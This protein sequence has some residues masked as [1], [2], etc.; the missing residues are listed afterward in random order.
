MPA[1]ATENSLPGKITFDQK[2]H[3]FISAVSLICGKTGNVEGLTL[4]IKTAMENNHGVVHLRCT[5]LKEILTRIH[6]C[7]GEGLYHYSPAV[8]LVVRLCTVREQLYIVMLCVFL[9][10]LSLCCVDFHVTLL[11]RQGNET[12]MRDLEV[13]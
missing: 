12:N 5:R 7:D 11:V 1:L 2:K 4:N 10:F 13:V 6:I 9:S 8:V 3:V